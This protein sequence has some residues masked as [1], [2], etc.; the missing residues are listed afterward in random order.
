MPKIPIQLSDGSVITN[1]N[2]ETDLDW[3]IPKYFECLQNC[4]KVS[5]FE[6]QECMLDKKSF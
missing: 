6:Q 1:E 5:L 4:K 3:K 2:I